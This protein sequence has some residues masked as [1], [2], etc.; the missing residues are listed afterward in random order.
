MQYKK[1]DIFPHSRNELRSLL[2]DEAEIFLKTQVY[3]K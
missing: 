3:N 1:C 2:Y